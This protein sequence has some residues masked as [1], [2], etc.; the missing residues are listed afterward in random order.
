MKGGVSKKTIHINTNYVQ[1]SKEQ[2]K[3]RG[4]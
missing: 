2:K 3:V 1:E 4:K